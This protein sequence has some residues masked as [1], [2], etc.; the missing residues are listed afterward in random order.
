MGKTIRKNLYGKKHKEGQDSRSNP[1][2]CH[3]SYCTGVDKKVLEEKI[4]RK[5]M[6]E[7]INNIGI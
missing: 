4:A 5:E 6:E 1:Y 3:C 7:A 2:I